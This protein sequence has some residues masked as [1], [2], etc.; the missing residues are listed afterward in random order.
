MNTVISVINKTQPA[1]G[2]TPQEAEV[3]RRCSSGHP[4]DHVLTT[5][6]GAPVAQAGNLA[7]SRTAV[8]SAGYR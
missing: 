3:A 4:S 8:A 5:A 6:R 2:I 7:P 1:N